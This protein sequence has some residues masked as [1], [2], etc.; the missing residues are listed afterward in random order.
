M[1]VLASQGQDLLNN[2]ATKNMKK[3]SIA[4]LVTIPALML[5]CAGYAAE[6]TANPKDKPD[7]AGA[8]RGGRNHRNLESDSR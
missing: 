2:Y 7:A 6:S 3:K 4:T 1:D 5:A 8:I